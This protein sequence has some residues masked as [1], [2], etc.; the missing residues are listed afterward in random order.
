MSSTTTAPPP[1]PASDGSSNSLARIIRTTLSYDTNVMLAAIISLLLVILFVLLLHLYTRW[2][3]VQA[4]RRS[5]T[6][7][8]VP[9]VLGSRLHHRFTIIDTSNPGNSPGKLGLPFSIISSLPLFVYKFSSNED[10]DYGL[11]CAICLSVFEEDEIGRKLPGCGHA[12][13]VECIDMWLHSHST[14]PICRAAIQCNQNHNIDH[15]EIEITDPG[16]DL[17][18]STI[19]NED[20]LR[21]EIVTTISNEIPVEPDETADVVAEND[22]GLD[23]SSSS[24]IGESLKM[25]LNNSSSCSCSCSSR[26]GGK[27]HPTS[28]LNGDESKA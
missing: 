20:V 7:V 19:N 16:Q 26:S 3:L 2:F 28:N 23:A 12:F 24:S 11:E 10:H 8:T 17:D 6:S 21:L 5:R 22:S 9:H 25:F 1:P 13:H 15:L 14:C 27:I 18:V 4:R